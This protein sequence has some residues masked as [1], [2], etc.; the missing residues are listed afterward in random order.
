MNATKEATAAGSAPPRLRKSPAPGG[1]T[2]GH[3]RRRDARGLAA[4][5]L[6]VL[7]GL[8]TPTAAADGL[9]LSLVRY[10]Q[11]EA[12]A[13]RGLLAACEP[14][15]KGRQPNP[16]KELAQLRH[17]NQRLQREVGRQ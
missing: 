8:R 13:L 2:L 17:D 10:Y 1:V 3:E 12:K 9:G 15:A 14:A 5:I 4:A 16:D 7:A 6:E 11:V